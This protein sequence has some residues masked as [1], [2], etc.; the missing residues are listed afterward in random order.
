MLHVQNIITNIDYQND[1]V[2]QI[3][4]PYMEHLGYRTFSN[5]TVSGIENHVHLERYWWYRYITRISHIMY[6]LYILHI[7]TAPWCWIFTS[8]CP[9]YTSMVDKYTSTMESSWDIKSSCMTCSSRYPYVQ[10]IIN[11]NQLYNY[12]VV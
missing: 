2:L 3:N 6:L 11:I 8:I 1:P 10:S 5:I 12:I 4:I 9:K 7:S